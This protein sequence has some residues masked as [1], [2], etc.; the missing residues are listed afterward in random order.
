MDSLISVAVGGFWYWFRSWFQFRSDGRLAAVVYSII[1][2][3]MRSKSRTILT[4]DKAHY[5]Y[6]HTH[7]LYTRPQPEMSVHVSLSKL[8][9]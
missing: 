8:M 5:N 9:L 2:F 6:T 4:V 3:V 7:T 1:C